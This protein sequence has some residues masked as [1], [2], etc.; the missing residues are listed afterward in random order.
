[1]RGPSSPPAPLRFA[2]AWRPA[3][4][5][6]RRI[7]CAD[8]ADPESERRLINPTRAPVDA[9]FRLASTTTAPRRRPACVVELTATS[10]A[11]TSASSECS[12][13]PA[14]LRVRA[15]AD[16]PGTSDVRRPVRSAVAEQLPFTVSVAAVEPTATR[17][18]TRRR[19][20]SPSSRAR[21]VGTRATTSSRHAGHDRI[22][23]LPAA[24]RS[25]AARGTTTSTR[26]RRRTSSPAA[27]AGRDPQQG[28]QRHDLR[29]RRRAGHDR[30]R[31]RADI[32]LADRLDVT[33]HCETVVRPKR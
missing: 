28:R 4:C 3:R 33:R 31:Q 8:L 12:G 17:A 30:L 11:L 15:A 2:P 6:A 13:L 14:A 24:T 32:V 21:S 19:A 29:A 26:E 16:P 1:V 5:R 23:A 20:S 27:R 10:A 25:T 22:C 7:R 9:P 18:R